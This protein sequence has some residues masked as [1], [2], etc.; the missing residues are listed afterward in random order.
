MEI[1]GAHLHLVKEDVELTMSFVQDY[2]PLHNQ[3]PILLKM[4]FRFFSVTISLRKYCCIQTCKVD[5]CHTKER[6]T[7]E[8][9]F[10]VLLFAGVEKKLGF[11][12]TTIIF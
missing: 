3:K 4:L 6:C 9:I 1:S 12:Y 2:T 10:G 5:G 11:G 8:R 7:K